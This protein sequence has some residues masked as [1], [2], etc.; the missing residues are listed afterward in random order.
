MISPAAVG[1]K[2]CWAVWSVQSVGAPVSLQLSVRR[3][4]PPPVPHRRLPVRNDSVVAATWAP[5]SDSFVRPHLVLD[6]TG[7]RSMAGAPPAF[8]RFDAEI[9]TVRRRSGRSDGPSLIVH[10][11]TRGLRYVRRKVAC[12]LVDEMTQVGN[13]GHLLPPGPCSGTCG[14][15]RSLWSSSLRV[16]VF[17]RCPPN[18]RLQPRRVRMPPRGVGCKAMFGVRWATSLDRYAVLYE[19]SVHVVRA[20]QAAVFSPTA[21]RSASRSVTMR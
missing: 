18:A 4:N 1:C 17:R 19:N 6:G 7:A 2:P 13:P 20:V 3:L 11:P 10:E 12:L 21:R 5:P 8:D 14:P 16:L 9:V 15:F